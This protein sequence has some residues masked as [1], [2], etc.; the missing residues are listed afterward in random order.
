MKTFFHFIKVTNL[1]F[2]QR[3]STVNIALYQNDTL[4]DGVSNVMLSKVFHSDLLTTE[5]SLSVHEDYN[6]FCVVSFINLGGEF[7][8]NSSIYFSKFLYNIKSSNW[9]IKSEN[10]GSFLFSCTGTFGVKSVVITD[11]TG[12]RVCLEC[13]FSSFSTDTGCT[14]ELVSS[15]S[16]Q[17]TKTFSRLSDTAK[18]CVFGVITGEYNV[19]VID[20]KQAVTLNKIIVTEDSI[21]LSL[22][23]TPTRIC[24]IC[25][26]SGISWF[27][28][29][30][31][32]KSSN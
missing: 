15:S 30:N 12:G 11:T 23:V 2:G 28:E 29:E 1:C 27:N 8:S 16:V 7:M 13:L 18:G 19:N 9:Y 17:H 4:V 25:T 22:E 3:P 5:T 21:K 10:V 6:Y 14:V 24:C 32:S 26:D 31:S 20:Y